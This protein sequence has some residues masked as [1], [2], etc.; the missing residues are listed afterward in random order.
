MMNEPLTQ[1]LKTITD[2]LDMIDPQW[3]TKIAAKGARMEGNAPAPTGAHGS[4][5]VTDQSLDGYVTP[6]TSYGANIREWSSTADDNPPLYRLDYGKDL[7]V[8]AWT[9]DVEGKINSA[10]G[11]PYVWY[12]VADGEDNFVR[13]DV[14][15][16][17]KD[18]PQPVVPHSSTGK[19][20]SPIAGRYAIENTHLNHRNH[21]GVDLSAPM[22]TNIINHVDAFVLRAFDCVLCKP[23]GDGAWTINNNDYGDGYGTFAILRYDSWSLPSA[24]QQHVER[25][26][27]VLYG[28]MSDIDVTQGFP[29]RADSRI[30]R[31][32]S[33]GNSSGPHLHL[34]VRTSDTPNVNFYSAKLID[35]ALIFD[36]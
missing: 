32:G 8:T 18:N 23:E 27:F 29:V 7:P 13:E 31:V 4:M 25:F 6:N 21:K 35:P 24:A 5:T 28:H 15:T 30:G 17:T 34:E 11:K 22:G 26:V 19:W 16:F 33:T 12:M 9:S 14:V 10:T 20:P 3:R 2:Y 36:L 1:E